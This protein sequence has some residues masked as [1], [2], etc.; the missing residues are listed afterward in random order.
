MITSISSTWIRFKIQVTA[1]IV[2]E[3]LAFW[4]AV[5]RAHS[6]MRVFQICCRTSEKVSR[7]I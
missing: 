2:A 3:F 1:T 7:C 5:E 4:A 6:I